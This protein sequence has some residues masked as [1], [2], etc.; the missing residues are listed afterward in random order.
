MYWFHFHII[1]LVGTFDL[2]C[3]YLDGAPFFIFVMELVALSRLSHNIR[4][5]IIFVPFSRNYIIFCIE[6][7]IGSVW[8]RDKGVINV[9]FIHL[10]E[11]NLLFIFLVLYELFVMISLQFREI[12]ALFSIIKRYNYPFFSLIIIFWL[13]NDLFYLICC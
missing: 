2:V 3:V 9:E 7:V 4:N 13:G 12:N 11:N 8:I 1:Y 6:N 10:S 5:S